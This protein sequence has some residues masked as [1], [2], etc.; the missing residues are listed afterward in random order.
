MRSRAGTKVRRGGVY[1]VLHCGHRP[2]HKAAL[3]AG[4]LFP[5]CRRCGT[6]VAFEFLEPLAECEEIEHIGYDPDF[7]DTVLRPFAE[8]G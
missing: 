5:G 2:S 1:E 3:Q 7:M 8:A 6:A 4:E